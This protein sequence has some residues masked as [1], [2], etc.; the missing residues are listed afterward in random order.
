[1]DMDGKKRI[2]KM[3]LLVDSS[4]PDAMYKDALRC[5][6]L[7]RLNSEH[8]QM[9]A[10]QIA[11]RLEIENDPNGIIAHPKLLYATVGDSGEIDILGVMIE[12]EGL[13]G[14]RPYA[15]GCQDLAETISTRVKKKGNF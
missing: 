4:I 1:M 11:S 8:S 12:E 10:V 15:I 5:K 14:L 13:F 3:R 2:A 7:F 6:V 9:N